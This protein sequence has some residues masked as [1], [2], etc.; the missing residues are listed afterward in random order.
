MNFLNELTYYLK[1]KDK[2]M[3][4]TDHLVRIAKAGGGLIIDASKYTT[5]HLVRIANAIQPNS[6]MILKNCCDVTIDHLV[7][8]AKAGKGNIIIED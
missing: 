2:H 6:Q 3:R 1:Q 7:R 5:D 8:I 4:T